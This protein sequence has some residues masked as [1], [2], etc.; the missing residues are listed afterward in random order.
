MSDGYGGFEIWKS[1]DAEF[2]VQKICES[3]NKYEWDGFKGEWECVGSSVLQLEYSEYRAQYPTVYVQIKSKLYCIGDDGAEYEVLIE[4]ATDKDHYNCVGYELEDVSIEKL[5]K[6]LSTNINT[7]WLEIRCSYNE[8][9]RL[10][11]CEELRIMAG[12][13]GYR[14]KQIFGSLGG[15]I[16]EREEVE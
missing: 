14:R 6:D 10:S 5:L 16:D 7:G 12:G 2:D 15:K 4:A 11:V 8:K 13:K 3:L 1:E 9:Q